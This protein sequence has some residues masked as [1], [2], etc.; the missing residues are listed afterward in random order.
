VG[1]I[2]LVAGIVF[3]QRTKLGKAMRAV[4]QDAD[5]ASALGVDFDKITG[6]TMAIASVLAGL[7]GVLWAPMGA[8]MYNAGFNV[9]LLAFVVVIVG[10][11]GSLVGPVLAAFII[12]FGGSL[13]GYYLGAN[14]SAIGLYSLLLL[15]LLIRPQGLFG[16]HMKVR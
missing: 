6:I 9:A 14:L 16:Y 8:I 5:A 1:L 2:I 7:Y 13:M 3:I 12:G 10:G 11:A 15:V 4:A